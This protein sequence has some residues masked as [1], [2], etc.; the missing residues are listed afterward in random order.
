MRRDYIFIENIYK[1][2]CEKNL[3]SYYALLIVH[4]TLSSRGDQE[5]ALLIVIVSRKGEARR[6]YK[7]LC[8]KDNF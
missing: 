1:I 7:R 5:G 8:K 2:Q 3:D 6:Q 4:Q